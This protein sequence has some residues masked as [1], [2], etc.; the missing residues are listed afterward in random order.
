MHVLSEH[1]RGCRTDGPRAIR[2]LLLVGPEAVHAG[3]AMCLLAVCVG[4]VRTDTK[5]ATGY[6]L[7]FVEAERARPAP[8][9]TCARL[10]GGP[11]RRR[12][13]LPASAQEFHRAFELHSFESYSTG[14]VRSA[15]PRS[16]VR[17]IDGSH[18]W[19]WAA[20]E[21]LG[22]FLPRRVASAGCGQVPPAGNLSADRPRRQRTAVLTGRWEAAGSARGGGASTP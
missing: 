2:R 18:A 17:A 21:G 22:F 20:R 11:A 19:R 1:G 9:D 15:P 5:S 14:K 16:R 6:R 10:V 7:R 8:S 4:P 3:S 13:R 12:S